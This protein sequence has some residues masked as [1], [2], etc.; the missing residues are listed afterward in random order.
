MG[1][2][3]STTSPVQGSVSR[4][5]V[6]GR[7]HVGASVSLRFRLVVSP[8]Y[9]RKKQEKF[10]IKKRKKKTLPTGWLEGKASKIT[11]CDHCACS[12]WCWKL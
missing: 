10:K 1:N 8:E 11:S 7:M 5:P 9:S 6:R 3:G 4:P 2:A 12:A